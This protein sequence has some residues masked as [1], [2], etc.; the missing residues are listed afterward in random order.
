[1]ICVNKGIS[2][3]SLRLENVRVNGNVT[4]KSPEGTGVQPLVN[5]VTSL[6]GKVG[7]RHA[8]AGARTHACRSP[9]YVWTDVTMLTSRLEGSLSGGFL[10]TSPM[11]RTQRAGVSLTRGGYNE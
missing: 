2:F 7:T 4:R 6:H 8:Q 5:I 1:M 10:V 3:T 11:Q 9:T